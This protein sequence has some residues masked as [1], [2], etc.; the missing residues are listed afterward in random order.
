M[1][2]FDFLIAGNQRHRLEVGAADLSELGRSIERT[3]FIEGELEPDEWGE[4]RQALIRSDRI[5]VVIEAD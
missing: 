2:K 3:R 4:I 5:Q 1:A